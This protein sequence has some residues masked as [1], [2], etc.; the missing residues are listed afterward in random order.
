MAEAKERRAATEADQAALDEQRLGRSVAIG[1]PL[2]TVVGGAIT[3]VVAGPA[4]GVLV[5]AAGLL[6][7]VIALGWASLRILSGDV[8]LSPELMALDSASR[9]ADSLTS[10]KNML[11]RALKD[12]ENERAIGKIEPEDYE[13]ITQ[14]YR[15]ELKTLLKRIDETLAPHRA[16]AEELVEAHF[17]K[18]GLAGEP[19]VTPVREAPPTRMTCPSCG[20]SNEAG[21]KF[22]KECA[23]KLSTSEES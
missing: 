6:L 3:A 21:A 23:T 15:S 18:V 5:L 14:T 19:T 4:T 9:G 12:L 16:K 17:R 8:A 11:L 13:Q 1:L 22:C 2:V 20:D 7:G 10:R